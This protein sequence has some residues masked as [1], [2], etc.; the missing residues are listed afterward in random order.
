[1]RAKLFSGYSIN[2]QSTVTSAAVESR[3]FK[4]LTLNVV[5]VLLD[6][7]TAKGKA[8]VSPSTVA[9]TL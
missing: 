9:I 6:T 4:T 5:V 1:M 3:N 8:E 7:A 2:N